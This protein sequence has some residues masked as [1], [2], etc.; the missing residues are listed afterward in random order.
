MQTT[1]MINKNINS[2]QAKCM[3]T[4]GAGGLPSLPG[5]GKAQR[6]RLNSNNA[7]KNHE[8]ITESQTRDKIVI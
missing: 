5:V 1:D 2:Y 6:A 3:K 7:D 4:G 8:H